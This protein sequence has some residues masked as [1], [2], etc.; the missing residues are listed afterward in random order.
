MLQG[1]QLS[2]PNPPP[3]ARVC[4]LTMSLSPFAG[5]MPSDPGRSSLDAGWS[6]ITPP[7]NAGWG[8]VQ[9]RTS[10]AVRACGAYGANTRW[11]QLALYFRRRLVGVHPSS[12]SQTPPFPPDHQSANKSVKCLPFRGWAGKVGHQTQ[13]ERVR[14]LSIHAIQAKP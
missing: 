1:V 11:R 7:P 13:R 4:K 3:A 8:I 5:G 12:I 2:I 14:C 10:S 9:P 6:I